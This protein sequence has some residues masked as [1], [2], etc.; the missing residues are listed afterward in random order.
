MLYISFSM[1]PEMFNRNGFFPFALLSA[2]AKISSGDVD[3]LMLSLDL[4]T[5][6]SESI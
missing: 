3:T 6:S 4:V 2:Y 5:M 1:K